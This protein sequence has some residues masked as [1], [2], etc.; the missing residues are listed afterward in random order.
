M[1]QI[2][3][4][5]ARWT[6]DKVGPPGTS[7]PSTGLRAQPAVWWG[8]SL[9]TAAA[10]LF[11]LFALPAAAQG[12]ATQL[13]P[14]GSEPTGDQTQVLLS[15]FDDHYALVP[16]TDVFPDGVAL[17]DTIYTD[18]Y[19]GTN[20]Y[21]TF[22]HGNWSYD[23][24]GIAG[25]DAG[26]IVAV[27]FDDL[28]PGNHGQVFYNQ[29]T[30]DDYVVVTYEEVAPYNGPNDGGGYNTLQIVLRPLPTG[31]S[32]DFQIELRYVALNWAQAAIIAPVWPTAG[33]SMGDEETYAEL[34]QSG[35]PDFRDLESGSNVGE[36]GVYRWNVQSG[37]VLSLPSVTVTEAPG[38]VTGT[39]A[40]TGGTVAD[41][42][43]E[44]VTERGL[45]YSTSP[46]PTTDDVVILSGEGEGSFDV[47]LSGLH[48]A[49]TYYLRAFATN[50]QGTAYGPQ[51]VLETEDVRVVFAGPDRVW[52]GDESGSI[53]LQ[54]VNDKDSPSVVGEDFEFQISLSEEQ[55]TA[56]LSKGM[57]LTVPAGSSGVSFKYLNTTV[58]S[59]L[60]EIFAEQVSGVSL[61]GE[62]VHEIQVRS[63]E[64]HSFRV[65][66]VGGAEFGI[67]EV[68]EP[69]PV[70][71]V[72]QDAYG[73]VAT[74]FQSQ[75][76][77]SSDGSL[78]TGGGASG[79]FQVGVLAEHEVTFADHGEFTLHV[80]VAGADVFSGS[81]AP[82]Q[83]RGPEA[84]VVISVEVDDPTPSL[85]QEVIVRVTVR[86]DGGQPAQGVAIADPL[87]GQ[88]RLETLEVN[89]TG[90]DWEE[91]D[92]GW[93]V[94][95]LDAGAEIEIEIRARVLD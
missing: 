45:V 39:T 7:Q 71:I 37:D 9:W 95:T 76:D 55:E 87:A 32:T 16:L 59:G 26:P 49:T 62:L 75:V 19:I 48:P 18:M 35:T 20:G 3:L 6:P 82:I 33:W 36:T 73:N 29:N 14:L 30:D 74:Q 25:Y 34:P 53:T 93:H 78:D 68:G 43:G 51:Q 89:V 72:A 65:E 8:S 46:T 11:A 10:A 67:Q 2:R 15:N 94:D 50:E 23:P 83:V 86:N 24:E 84:D 31:E 4:N 79:S 69:F 64:L 77:V 57:R 40:T 61:P 17:G 56:W 27:Q 41:D 42:G 58:G 54:V 91:T 12:Q 22:G 60:H 92:D 47:F 85:G 21:V 38:D 28:N 52:A 70:R 90:G 1:R 63:S 5:P 13:T 80:E 81:S 66:P 44:P 88:D